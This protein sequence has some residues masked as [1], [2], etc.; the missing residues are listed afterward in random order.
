MGHE[1]KSGS[2]LGMHLPPSPSQQ[3]QQQQSAAAAAAAAAD[4]RDVE[5]KFDDEEEQQN[6]T[7]TSATFSPSST[8]QAHKKMPTA[9]AAPAQPHFL[10]WLAVG[11]GQQQMGKG[12]KPRKKSDVVANALLAAAR[13]RDNSHRA[14]VAAAAAQQQRR[15][16]SANN[17]EMSLNS[18]ADPNDEESG[19]SLFSSGVNSNLCPPPTATDMPTPQGRMLLSL[20]EKLRSMM[21][22]GQPGP[23]RQCRSHM[24]VNNSSEGEEEEEAEKLNMLGS[25]NS[26]EKIIQHSAEGRG[27][28]YGRKK[29]SVPAY[30]QDKNHRHSTGDMVEFHNILVDQQQQQRLPESPKA[31]GSGSFFLATGARLFRSRAK[32]EAKQ[33]ET[34]YKN[35]SNNHE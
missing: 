4:T 22:P 9:A 25:A 7:S 14:T 28:S 13:Q 3:Q 2:E 27:S 20:G 1:L 15:R 19:C 16:M 30:A 32:S 26:A 8:A 11:G 34:L 6:A 31:S 5:P 33:R 24:D 23:V 18:A 35:S 12:E 17:M 29:L 10:D 21:T